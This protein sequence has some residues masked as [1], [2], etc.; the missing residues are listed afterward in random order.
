M[1]I[2]LLDCQ[3]GHK[4]SVELHLTMD[5]FIPIP[6][7]RYGLSVSPTILF[8]S[9]LP[10]LNQSQNCHVKHVTSFLE[11]T[12]QVLVAEIISSVSVLSDSTIMGAHAWGII[13]GGWRVNW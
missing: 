9:L 5:Q 8:L 2:I 4:N 10:G 11:I 1:H 3:K 13:R 7:V 6:K 12:Q